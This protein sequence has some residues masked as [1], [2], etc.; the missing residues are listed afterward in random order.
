MSHT[1]PNPSDKIKGRRPRYQKR[2]RDYISRSI[3]SL[4]EQII[5]IAK[6][7]L[8]DNSSIEKSASIADTVMVKPVKPEKPPKPIKPSQPQSV[9]RDELAPQKVVEHKPVDD[10]NTA[11][12][13]R[14]K[15]VSIK[16]HEKP[17]SI[18]DTV[19]LG[20][21]KRVSQEVRDYVALIAPSLVPSLSDISELRLYDVACIQVK[22]MC[23]AVTNDDGKTQLPMFV[24]NFIDRAEVPKRLVEHLSKSGIYVIENITSHTPVCVAMSEFKDYV[25]LYIIYSFEISEKTDVNSLSLVHPAY[26]SHVL[27][28]DTTL[29][30]AAFFTDLMKRP[31]YIFRS[32]SKFEDNCLCD[33]SPIMVMENER[34]ISDEKNFIADREELT[35]QMEHL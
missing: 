32:P 14:D 31:G 34:H 2:D 3:E 25:V 33:S 18:Q 11:H 5:P 29:I 19:V 23:V 8:V 28:P 17:V 27:V 1:I 7:I 9:Q 26:N 15:K 30:A 21:S 13:K 6:S 20:N 16:L 10:R 12:K 24:S 35:I 22:D 4:P